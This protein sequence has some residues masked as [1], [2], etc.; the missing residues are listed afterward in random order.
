[1]KI[2]VLHDYAHVFR[3]TRVYPRLHDHEVTIHTEVYTKPKWV[4]E[5]AMGGEALL[6]T[7]QHVPLTRQITEQLPDLW[8]QRGG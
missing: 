4:V 1:M 2:A 7:Q 8:V 3:E 5:P 6:L